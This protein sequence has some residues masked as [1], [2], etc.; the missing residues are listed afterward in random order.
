MLKESRYVRLASKYYVPCFEKFKDTIV[1]S[2][3]EQ[4]CLYDV[5]AFDIAHNK[6]VRR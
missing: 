5:A 4:P 1:S 6:T 3:E 2:P